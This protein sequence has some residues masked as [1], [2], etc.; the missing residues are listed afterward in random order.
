LVQ[1]GDGAVDARGEA[2]VVGVKDE[3]CGHGDWMTLQGQGS[4]RAT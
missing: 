1:L 4:Q 2:E 3:A